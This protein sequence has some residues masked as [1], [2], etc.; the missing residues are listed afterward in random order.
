VAFGGF[1]VFE[2]GYRIDPALTADLRE[3]PVPR[4]RRELRSFL[5]LAQ[6]LGTFTEEVTHLV[7]PLRGLNTN[8]AEWQWLPQHQKAFDKARETLAGEA[9]DGCIPE[10]NRIHAAAADQ[11]WLAHSPV[12]L[13]GTRE[14]RGQ[15]DG[16]G[17]A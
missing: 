13:E 11:G 3:F 4:D 9:R 17:R 6:Q 1:E 14:A 15:L 16:H 7:E 10:R 2:G 12:W 5:G 8:A